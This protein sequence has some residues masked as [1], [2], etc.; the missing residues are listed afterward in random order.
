MHARH[1]ES[2]PWIFSFR[3]RRAVF[4][5]M[6]EKLALFVVS[7]NPESFSAAWKQGSLI[8]AI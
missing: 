7:V 3:V 1:F 2:R 6:P 8:A 4:H 5:A